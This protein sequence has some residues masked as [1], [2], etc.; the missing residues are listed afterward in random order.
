M[1]ILVYGE[2]L[3]EVS[4]IKFSYASHLS[5]WHFIYLELKHLQNRTHFFLSQ[6]SSSLSLFLWM[7]SLPPKWTSLT[8]FGHSVHL[9]TSVKDLTTI[10]SIIL[11]PL[12]LFLFPYL[13]FTFFCLCYINS[14]FLLNH[15]SV[16]YIQACELLEG[17][18]CPFHL[19]SLVPAVYISVW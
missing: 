8:F 16:L 14:I 4:R 1:I 5:C 17:K 18:N 9:V 2:K 12:L 11:L 15:S 19:V 13:L 3:K 7:A 6:T 10:A